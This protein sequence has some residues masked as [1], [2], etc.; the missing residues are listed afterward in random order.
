MRFRCFLV[1]GAVAGLAGC[2]SAAI[3]DRA[4][5][6]I[7]DAHTTA[8]R[9]SFSPTCPDKGVVSGNCG[10]VLKGAATED[11]RVKF[12]DL[13]CVDKDTAQCELL[14]Q[15][16]L[17]ATLKQRYRLADWNEV[18]LTCD[19]N[20]GKCDDPVAYELLLVDS[21]N[22]R[23]RDDYAREE[24]EIEHERRSAQSRHAAEQVAV[25]GAVLGTV[26]AVTARG[27]VCHS[28]PSAFTGVTTTVCSP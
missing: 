15:R 11:F 14:Y 1:V 23:V 25:A 27:P 3:D 8:V 5:D 6:R 26:A 13:K 24:N 12:R 2:R 4:N 10:L 28:Y 17:D 7:N 22:V 21:H 9:R 20:P 16:M 19:A 18:T